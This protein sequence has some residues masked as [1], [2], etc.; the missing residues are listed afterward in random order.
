GH[1][2]FSRDWSSDVCSSDL[3][4][5]QFRSDGPQRPHVIRVLVPA[6][7]LLA[8]EGFCEQY[9]V[10]VIRYRRELDVKAFGIEPRLFEMV[11]GRRQDRKSAG[12]GKREPHGTTG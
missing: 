11:A 3:M 12:E 10:R 2:R 8:G 9:R 4:R 7:R 6:M 1:T 5:K